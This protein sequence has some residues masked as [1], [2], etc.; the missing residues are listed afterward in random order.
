MPYSL[1]V[2]PNNYYVSNNHDEIGLQPNA[3]SYDQLSVY[4]DSIESVNISYQFQK[5]IDSHK[6]NLKEIKEHTD[7]NRPEDIK[8]DEYIKIRLNKIERSF[9]DLFEHVHQLREEIFGANPTPSEYN[10]SITSQKRD[11]YVIA[12]VSLNQVVDLFAKEISNIQYI[13]ALNIEE[14]QIGA[15]NGKGPVYKDLSQLR[16]GKAVPLLPGEEDDSDLECG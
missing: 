3:L 6:E 14:Q 7:K 12:L 13:V 8:K 5:C 16:E 15:L 9:D 2:A 4:P 10:E 11:E 1:S